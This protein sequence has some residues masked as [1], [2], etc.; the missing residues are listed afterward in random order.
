MH[1]LNFVLNVRPTNSTS[2]RLLERLWG[3]PGGRPMAWGGFHVM[4]LNPLVLLFFSNSAML[5]G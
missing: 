3:E 1:K 4:F 5:Q 2:S